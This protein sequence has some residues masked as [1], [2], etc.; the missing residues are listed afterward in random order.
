MRSCPFAPVGLLACVLAIGCERSAESESARPD[1][2][3][4]PTAMRRAA[5]EPNDA[6]A[7]VELAPIGSRPN[8]VIFLIDTL[9]ADRL[10]LYGYDRR[11]TS[12]RLDAL[13]AE[14]VV[15][16]QA[17]APGPWTL[18]SVGSLF[19]STFACEH[20]LL[21][22]RHKLNRELP[23]LAQWM[24]RSGYLTVSLFAN[25][26]AGP[27]FGLGRGFEILKPSTRNNARRVEAV[28]GTSP[29]HAFFLYIHNMEP[30]DP[31][32]HAPEEI[33]GFDPVEEDVRKRIEEHFHAYKRAAEH[34]YRQRLPLGTTDLSA[35]QDE[36]L[37][38]LREM[39]DAWN[40]LYDAC[41]FVADRRV[42]TVVDWLRQ[43]G[44]W[45]NTL[46]IVTSDH[47]EEFG[48]HGGWLHDQ[49]VYEE[50]LRVPLLIRFPH[51]EFAGTRIPE[52]V[53]LVDV[54]PTLL[55]YLEMGASSAVM[56]GRD[57]MPRLRGHAWEPEPIR[58]VGMR[59]NTTR[60]YRPWAETRGDLNVALR[61]G[62]WKG[63]WNESTDTFELYDL[64]VDAYEQ[65]N[66]VAD[67]AELV[68]SMRAYARDWLENC[69]SARRDAL[70]LQELSEETLRNLRAL[71]YVE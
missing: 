22:R 54:M 68:E 62:R 11:Q 59:H 17:A 20:Q 71:G 9:R 41:V 29:R 6:F 44:L 32:H 67:H 24:R 70:E 45:D 16:E 13:A 43:H 25:A 33:E 60:Y 5:E 15:F 21:S 14:S 56:R 63:I 40:E 58:V 23:T 30:H 36:H 48:E 19:T 1:A 46:F 66:V 28:L 52:P 51:G 31:H 55:S 47:G 61:S 27:E 8:V 38:A 64:A 53:S 26:F 65:Q 57:L 42:G 50:L 10:G 34:D 12:P 3:A 39:L 69:T 7:R 35:E 18:P 4:T 37:A 2:A 49:S